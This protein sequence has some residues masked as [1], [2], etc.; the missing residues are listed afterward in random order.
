MKKVFRDWVS[1]LRYIP[2]III[3]ETL[4]QYEK[5]MKL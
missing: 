3:K 4:Y 5:V 2:A 1:P